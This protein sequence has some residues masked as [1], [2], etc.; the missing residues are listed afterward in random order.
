[1]NKDISIYVG[2]DLHEPDSLANQLGD[3]LP[4]P[5]L[6]LQPVIKGD[7]NERQFKK[8]S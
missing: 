6:S 8:Y 1:V 5:V 4:R 7:K 2:Q 3:A